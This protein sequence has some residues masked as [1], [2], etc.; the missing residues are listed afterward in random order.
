[1]APGVDAPPGGDS[2]KSA[3]LLAFAL[4]MSVGSLFSARPSRQRPSRIASDRGARNPASSDARVP[5]DLDRHHGHQHGRG[6]SAEK[7]SS[8][9]AKGWKDILFRVYREFSDDRLLAV[10]AG[11]TFYMLLALFPAIGAFIAIYGLFADPVQIQGHLSALSGVLPEGGITIIGEQVQ[12]LSA[13]K[14]STLGIG[15]VT[16]ILISLWSANTGMKAV[17]DAL[18]VV[19]EEE[20]KRSFLRLNLISLSFTLGCMVIGIVAIAGVVFVPIILNAVGLGGSVQGV[21][22]SLVRWPLMLL[23]F[24]AA[25]AVLYRYGPS[26]SRAKWRWVTWG[27]ILAAV[28]WLGGS[29]LFSWYVSN[30]GSYNETYGS[31]GAAVGLMMWMWLSTSIVL[32][33]GELNAEL[34]HQTAMDSTAK[35]HRPLGERGAQMADT[36]GAPQ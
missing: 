21:V 7:P 23:F 36:V 24:A 16:G 1:M 33:C 34:E 20:E 35:P 15:A 8:M 19:Y 5:S 10:A 31:L 18:N 12:S 29:A 2:K 26:R 30:F 14:G 22:I 25:I 17:F 13:Q 6:R 11:V 28:L 9:P 27:A 4:G 3:W 32:L